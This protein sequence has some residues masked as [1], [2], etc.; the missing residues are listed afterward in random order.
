MTDRE[1]LLRAVCENPDDDL[2]R[3]VFADWLDEHD[4]PERAHFV[5]TQVEF[6]RLAREG[7]GASKE[8]RQIDRAIWKQHGKQWQLELPQ[9][10][11]VEWFSE[12]Y[13]GFVERVY[14]ESDKIL[15]DHADSIFASAPVQHL[16]ITTFRGAASFSM[17]DSLRHLKTLTITVGRSKDAAVAELLLCKQFRESLLLMVSGLGEVHTRELRRRFSKQ[18]L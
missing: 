15:V 9:I 6:A 13:R 18:L 12:C 7:Q 11:G 16:T 8:L 1:A 14:V 10:H 4:E 17:L 3:L 2:P 5:R